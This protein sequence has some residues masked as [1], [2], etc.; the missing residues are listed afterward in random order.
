[1]CAISLE[2]F[3]MLKC[4]FTLKHLLTVTWNTMANVYIV[5]YYT[6][7]VINILNNILSQFK[8]L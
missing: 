6:D 3:L 1:M 7:L 8:H 4:V 2:K 5:V